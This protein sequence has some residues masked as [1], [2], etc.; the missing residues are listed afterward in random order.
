[1]RTLVEF[2]VEEY[3]KLILGLDLSDVTEDKSRYFNVWRFSS[4][5]GDYIATNELTGYCS[6]Q[7]K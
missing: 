2:E 1:M 7:G 3:K 4:T 6:E 5:N